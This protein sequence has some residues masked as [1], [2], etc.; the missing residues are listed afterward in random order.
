MPRSTFLMVGAAV[1]S[2][3]VTP[4]V[5]ADEAAGG[6]TAYSATLE[7]DLFANTDRGYT[8]G[9]GYS[10]S[11]LVG[12]EFTADNLPRWIFNLAE[13]TYITK[14]AGKTRAVSYDIVQTMQT[15]S[16][17]TVSEQIEG[18]APYAGSL[19]WTVDLHAYDD[20]V[21]D[22]VALTLGTVGPL[23][24]AEQSQ[25]VIHQIVGS[26]EPQGWDNQ[27][28]NE[29]VFQVR[30]ERLWR[31]G[32]HDF[33]S[34][35][36]FDAIGI[37][38]GAIGN[39]GSSVAVGGTVRFGGDLKASF[40]T[41]TFLPNRRVSVGAPAGA[42]AWQVFLSVRGAFVANDIRIN[43]NTF[44]EGYSVPLEHWQAQAAAGATWT[45][46]KWGFVATAV[47]AT[48]RFTGEESPSKFGAFSVTYRH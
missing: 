15:P 3:V 18:D 8:N 7:N 48:R 31:L 1:G 40:P 43:G 42:S 14:T 33:D 30:A 4:I 10:W 38:Q 20:A 22:T 46:G 29:P 11:H 47:V 34:G 16:D 19:T 44:Q 26:D 17:I 13:H 2:L 37:G 39:L 45:N 23:S 5:Q 27:I 41:A 6:V 35:R 24:L 36:G 9:V 28:D 21:S 32:A 25:K 12:K